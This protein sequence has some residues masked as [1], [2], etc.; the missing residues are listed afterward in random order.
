[1][2]LE[3]DHVAVAVHAIKPALKLYRDGLGGEY[4]MGGDVADT[5]RWV[6]LRFP[7]G[8][9]VEL[10]EPLGEGFLSRFLE[11]RGEGMHHIT[12]KTDDIHAA[13]EHLEGLGMELVDKQL[14]DPRLEGGVPAA[15]EVARDADPGGAVLHS[16]RRRQAPPAAGEP[17]RA[18]VVTS[19]PVPEVGLYRRVTAAALVV[20]P[21]LLLLDNILHPKEYERDNEAEQLREIAA[22]ADRWQ[23]AH[24]IGFVAIVVFAA[25]VLGLAFLVRRRQPRLGLIGG[26]LGIVG[27]MS[28]AAV[29]SLD[30]F[31]WGVLGEVSG[32]P[33]VD[34]ATTAIALHEVQQSEMVA[35]LLPAH[36]GVHRRLRGARDRR[37]PPGRRARLGRRAARARRADGGRRDR[38]DQQ[39]VLHHRLGGPAGGR[40]GRGRGDRPHERRGLRPRRACVDASG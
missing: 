24:A 13:I 7:G 2:K 20:A 6:Q 40:R 3:L 34:P 16:R 19:V 38:R 31:T 17:R 35:G 28:F 22:H 30:G 26:A 8:G 4:L 29:I 25:A 15:F 11:K 1:M 39:R 33:G 10:L 14:D 27:L 23:L 21:A 12:F 5:W 18:D 36:A 9:K 32:R 37:R